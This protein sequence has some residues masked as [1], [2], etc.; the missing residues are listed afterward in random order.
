MPPAFQILAEPNGATDAMGFQAAGVGC[1]IRGQSKD[2]LDLALIYSA[3]PCTAAGVFTTNAFAAPPVQ[4]CRGS[5]EEGGPFHGLVANSG[6][7]NACTGP[8]GLLDAKAMA[9][10]AAQLTKSPGQSFFV[11]STGRI[12]VPLPMT[13]IRR[14]IKQAAKALSEK[15]AAGLSASRAILTSDSREKLAT[16]RIPWQGKFVTVTGMAKGA[17]MIEP[18]MATMLAFLFTDAR[19]GNNVLQKALRLAVAD[20][21]NAITVDGDMSTNDTVLLLANGA[22]GISVVSKAALFAAFQGAVTTVCSILAD[23]IVSDGEKITKVVEVLVRGARRESE[24]QAIARAIG[25]SLLVKSSWFG[26]DPNWGR[27]LDAAGYAGVTFD[28]DRLELSYSP[29]PPNRRTPPV[30]AFRK[31]RPIP[32]NKPKWKTIVSASRFA[33]ILDLHSGQASYRLLS[34][35][36]TEGYV[37]YNKSE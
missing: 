22:S 8:Q 30:P 9:A 20:T 14:G 21:F 36:L 31:G 25:N 28:P 13:K 6:N 23:K 29:S 16:V 26:N 2:R 1:D 12:G 27:L 11:C 10:Q 18:N 34:T 33:V 19:A 3:S 37:N 5:L 35:D 15:P 24:A 7:A 32:A 17:G 4:A